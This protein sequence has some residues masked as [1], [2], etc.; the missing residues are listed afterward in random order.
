[1]S[2]SE[3]ELETE[4]YTVPDTVDGIRLDAW[5]ASVT[6]N[7]LSRNRITDLIKKG[8]VLV[9]GCV[10]I[11]P[12]RKVLYGEE[13]ALGIPPVEPAD[14]QPEALPL[15]IRYEDDELLVLFKPA[16]LVVHPAAGNESGTLVNRLLHHCG[17][18][19]TG[20]GG[21][22][23]PGIVHRIDKNT[24]GLMVVAKTQ[25][26]H[27]HLSNQFADHGRKGA[28]ER[29]YLCFC[30]GKPAQPK[31]TM[32]TH[33]GRSSGSRRKRAV[34]SETAP[35]AKHAITHYETLQHYPA[36]KG[37]EV[38]ASLLRCHLETGRTHQIRVHMSH[39]GIPLVGDPEYATHFQTR[40]NRLTKDAASHIATFSRQALHAAVLGF[41]HPETGE[42]MHFEEELPTDMQK[43][44]E[45]LES[46]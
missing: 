40:L 34:V 42:I 7:H 21:V 39:M 30:W 2:D 14:P 15:H 11:S 3:G 31:G 44:Q 45:I 33:L 29:S 17:D 25:N 5:L 24:S 12:K 9:N 38:E 35:D 10:E 13:V 20:I 23:R 46:L 22:Q 27:H 32:K 43:L 6:P 36:R 18:S 37:A 19:L 8:K 41:M 28:L 26:A 4:A 1:L 16:G